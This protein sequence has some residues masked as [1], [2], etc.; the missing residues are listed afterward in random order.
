MLRG[1]NAT[2]LT[3]SPFPGWLPLGGVMHEVRYH[4]IQ[5]RILCHIIKME[6]KHDQPWPSLGMVGGEQLAALLIY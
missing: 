4:P 3:P 5:A 2:F 6:M 1:F